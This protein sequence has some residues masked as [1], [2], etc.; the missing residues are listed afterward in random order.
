MGNFLFSCVN[1]SH[2]EILTVVIFHS[3]HGFSYC[4]GLNDIDLIDSLQ[5]VHSAFINFIF[6]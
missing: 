3:V 6:C 5:Y 4:I 1:N 2:F